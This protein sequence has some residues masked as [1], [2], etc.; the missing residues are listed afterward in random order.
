MHGPSLYFGSVLVFIAQ[1]LPKSHVEELTAYTP[2]LLCG[3]GGVSSAASLLCLG[4]L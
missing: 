3:S 4:L 2:L 1:G